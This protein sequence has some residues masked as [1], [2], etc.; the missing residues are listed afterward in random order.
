VE[1]A[2]VNT[3]SL[4]DDFGVNQTVRT[5][6][7]VGAG[8]KTSLMY[9]LA[10][11][12]AVKGKTVITTTTTKI[13]TPEPHESPALVLLA[14]DPTLSGLPQHLHRYRHATVASTHL[15]GE[16]LDGVSLS[17]VETLSNMA[18]VVI[19]EADGASHLPVKAPEQW[20]PVIPSHTD[21]VIPVV[22]LD[23]LGKPA[24][25]EWVFR[26]ERFLHVTGLSEGELISPDAIAR[27]L[28][29][30]DGGLKGVPPNAN[31]IPFL[32]KLDLLTDRTAVV[33]LVET[34]RNEPQSR[35]KKLVV[36]KLLCGA[37]TR[38]L[39]LS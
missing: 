10:R 2:R 9:A 34:L 13:R 4:V 29:H 19:V 23:C 15:A 30:P 26:L 6:A 36:G 18:H 35:V 17:I 12:L 38:S 24:S 20:E 32:N 16:K 27:L 22:G 3:S 11:E 8:G 37:P 31:V 5:I 21:L 33:R 39:S 25:K 7:V 1:R 14:A 28:V